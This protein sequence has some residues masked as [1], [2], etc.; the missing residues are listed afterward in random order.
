MPPFRQVLRGPAFWRALSTIV[1]VGVLQATAYMNL[2]VGA[3]GLLGRITINGMM[4][5]L[6][7]TWAM[8]VSLLAMRRLSVAALPR[9]TALPAL[10]RRLRLPLTLSSE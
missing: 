5:G 7:I 4:E 3:K 10:L 2:I 8:F 9:G 6:M 1:A